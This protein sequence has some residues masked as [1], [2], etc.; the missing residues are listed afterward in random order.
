MI[1]KGFYL[2]LYGFFGWGLER[3]I[4]LMYFGYWY[5]N[6]VLYSFVQP[7]YGLG[8]VLTLIGYEV[9]R[10]KV[11]H[12]GI[13]IGLTVLIGVGATMVSEWISGVGYEALFGVLLWDYRLAFSLCT[14]PY[15]CI[16]PSTLFG[17]LAAFTVVYL[18]PHIE[19][20]VRWIPQSLKAA[21]IFLV[22]LDM[23]ITYLGVFL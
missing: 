6:R 18:H 5:E 1:Q 8:V 10:K 22:A 17:V 23:M 7:M 21:I 2:V 15:V 3:V 19:V 9:L 13:L 11:K 20:W 12:S 14:S 4:N 16:V